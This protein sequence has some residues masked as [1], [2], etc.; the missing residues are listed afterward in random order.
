[1]SKKKKRSAY[2]STS[3]NSNRKDQIDTI[4]EL[5]KFIRKNIKTL[6]LFWAIILVA[7]FNILGGEF[8]TADDPELIRYASSTTIVGAL[9]NFSIP[10][11]YITVIHSIF[12]LSAPAFHTGSVL[13]QMV[14]AVLAFALLYLVSKDKKVA[15]LATL[16]FCVHPVGSEAVAWLSGR[17]YL[18]LFLFTSTALISFILYTRNSNKYYLLA[19]SIIYLA[20]LMM[21][22]NPWALI[23]PFMVVGFDQFLLREKITIKFKKIWIYLP[24]VAATLLYV[25]VFFLNRY[26]Q[27]VESLAAKTRYD[28]SPTTPLINRIPYTVYMTSRQLVWPIELT[29]YHD[30]KIITKS[31]YTLMIA[32]TVA[33]TGITIYLW[34]RD[35][36]TAR[37]M[38]LIFASIL[39]SF[40]PVVI[41]WFIADR[42]LYMGSLLFGFLI[43]RLLVAAEKKYKLDDLAAITVTLLVLFYS[44]RTAVRTND[45]KTNKN[46]WIATQKTAPYSKRVYNNLGDVYSREQN[47][48]LAV[49]NFKR[50]AEISPTYAEAI[51]N[52]GLTYMQMGDFDNARKYLIQSYQIN[53]TIYQAL[54]KLG[55]IEYKVGNVEKALEYLYAAREIAPGDPQ[56][57]AAL[58]LVQSGKPINQIID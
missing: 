23:I 8:V 30:G 53:P 52:L 32:I 21:W 57:V 54:H 39:P 7:Y 25:G 50:A 26:S 29:I 40:S 14:N 18:F 19:S 51:H 43:V 58:N 34:K 42:Y 13:F 48:E 17:A 36:V 56:V 31:L 9:K 37:L 47:W 38:V 35:K 28:P 44:I 15:T 41:A 12:G 5:L 16:L 20:A 2:K 49:A 3:Q 27:R 45:F 24:Y 10:G 46:L 33:V 55:M 1:M 11:V 6:I 22:R 4:K